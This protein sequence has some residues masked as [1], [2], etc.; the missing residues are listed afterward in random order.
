MD[1]IRETPPESL[2]S[3]DLKVDD[4]RIKPL[5]FRYRARNYPMT[6]DYAE[7]QKWKHHCQD[8][9]EDNLPT[10]M[11]NFESLA[12]THQSNEKKMQILKDLYDYVN[13]L[14]S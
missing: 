8:F 4:K 3:L 12:L 13:N 9:F 5:L 1:I 14:V 6:L 2:G 7:Q 10:Y 11:E